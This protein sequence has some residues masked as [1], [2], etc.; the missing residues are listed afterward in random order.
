MM[1]YRE[2]LEKRARAKIALQKHLSYQEPETIDK[3]FLTRKY[4][5]LLDEAFSANDLRV[6]KDTLVAL[7]T[8]HFPQTSSKQTKKG[9]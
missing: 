3:E 8:L 7:Q 4:L 5:R 1:E 6:A 9:Q 2:I